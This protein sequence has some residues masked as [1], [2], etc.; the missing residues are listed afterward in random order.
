MTPREQA[1]WHMRELERLIRAD[2]GSR[3]VVQASGIYTSIEDCRF[4]G[5]HLSGRLTC[6]DNL[7]V[8]KGGAA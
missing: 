1:I 3:V 8:P 2:G 5:I 4:I 6:D 7:F